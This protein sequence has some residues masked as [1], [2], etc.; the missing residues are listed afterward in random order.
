MSETLTEEDLN[1]LLECSRY[2]ELE[3][4][5]YLLDAGADINYRR[6][7]DGST[8]LHMAS[9]NGHLEIVSLLLSRGA[10]HAANNAGNTPLHWACL[11]GKSEVAAKLLSTCAPGEIDVYVKN[12]QGKSAFTVAIS[13]G[14]EEL[15]RSMLHHSSAEPPVGEVGPAG[16]A[17][18][19]EDI[20]DEDELLQGKPMEGSL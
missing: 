18:E 12:V 7:E 13:N 4:L 8:A 15:A 10:K 20:A 6:P 2:G 1:E 14:H 11:N 3:D 19:T 17:E 9:A 16:V 5:T